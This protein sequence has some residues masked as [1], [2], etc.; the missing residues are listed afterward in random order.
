MSPSYFVQIGR[1]VGES[2]RS[3][4]ASQPS[5]MSCS[6]DQ[7]IGLTC[8]KVVVPF[9]QSE[10][11][12]PSRCKTIIDRVRLQRM[13]GPQP[14][15]LQPKPVTSRMHDELT[16]AA[17]LCARAFTITASLHCLSLPSFGMAT[18]HNTR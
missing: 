1:S 7:A 3:N 12:K 6:V 8:M 9:R 14:S 4:G 11:E 10:R 15:K 17:T 2:L 5:R 16:A 13:G 18:K